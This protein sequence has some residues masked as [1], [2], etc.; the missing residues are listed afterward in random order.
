[1]AGGEFL[2]AR[3]RDVSKQDIGRLVVT[4]SANGFS[5]TAAAW[6][7]GDTVRDFAHKITS[8]PLNP[9]DV[10]EIE[11]GFD[12]D[13]A[14]VENVHVAMRA[15]PVG[16]RGQVGLRIRLA[17]EI[18]QSQRPEEQH[19][20]RLELLTSYQRLAPFSTDLRALVDGTVDVARIDADR[21]VA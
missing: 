16:S 12:G 7:N 17:T 6:F 20:V 15:Y 5:G 14:F 13:D 11:G 10:A 9:G 21:F 1:M 2:E 18:Q 4:A 3:W 8:Y 19:H